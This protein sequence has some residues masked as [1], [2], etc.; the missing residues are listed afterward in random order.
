MKGEILDVIALQEEVVMV[1]VEQ[2]M[3]GDGVKATAT[4]S[5]KK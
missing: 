5:Q 2:T 3:A 1:T 4:E